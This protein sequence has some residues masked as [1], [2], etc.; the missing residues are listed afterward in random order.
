VAALARTHRKS[1]PDPRKHEEYAL[2]GKVQRQ[3]VRK[4]AALLRL[5]DAL[6][7]EHRQS[8]DRVLVS[9]VGDTIALDLVLHEDASEI[10]P[11][12][13]MRKCAL[14]EAELGHRLAVTV[15][16]ATTRATPGQAGDGRVVDGRVAG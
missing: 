14:F 3:Q 1:P 7:T 12:T 8:I 10:D 13:L 15:G 6:D 2:L 9:R 5:A 16:P 11:A 4:L